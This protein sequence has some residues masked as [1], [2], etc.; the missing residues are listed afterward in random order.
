MTN[1]IIDAIPDVTD[2]KNDLAR[3]G[4]EDGDI[5]YLAALQVISELEAKLVVARANALR[6]A[7]EIAR[8][9][10]EH[11]VAFPSEVANAILAL[12]DKEQGE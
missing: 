5:L 1:D 12:S 3:R 11:G 10:H 4:R 7:A 6:E 9:P 2:V 8:V